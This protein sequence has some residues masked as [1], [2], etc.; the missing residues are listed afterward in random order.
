M[1][2]RTWKRSGLRFLRRMILKL[3]RSKHNTRCWRSSCKIQ[4]RRRRR[5]HSRVWS[6]HVWL[7]AC[8]MHCWTS[9]LIYR[10]SDQAVAGVPARRRHNSGSR[11]RFVLKKPSPRMRGDALHCLLVS[12][13]Q[14]VQAERAQFCVP[15]L[16]SLFVCCG[17]QRPKLRQRNDWRPCLCLH[18]SSLDGGLY[19]LASCV[20]HRR[21]A[22]RR[23][24]M[25]ATCGIFAVFAAAWFA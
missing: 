6:G 11:G 12:C 16:V 13:V 21:C 3:L 10:R 23:K 18:V 24:H 1:Q 4:T 15:L 8:K 19:G 5:M 17:R 9:C 14:M 2:A 7:S 25:P 20:V 22:R